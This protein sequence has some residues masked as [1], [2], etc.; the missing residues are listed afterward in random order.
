[1]KKDHISKVKQV[2][3]SNNKIT[4]PVNSELFLDI[5]DQ[6]ASLFSIGPYYYYIFNF[7]NY[8][9]DFVHEGIENV[10]GIKPDDFTIDMLFDIMHPENLETLHLKELHV[11]DF[12]LNQIPKEDLMKYKAMYLMRL[13]NS[14]GRY[15]TILHQV[16]T[17]TMSEEGKMQQIIGVH[18]DVTYLNVPFD[19]RISFIG[20]E[21]PSFYSITPHH[22]YKMI[23]PTLGNLF[24]DREK[25][26]LKKVSE[27]NNF[28][29]IADQLNLSPHTINTHKKNILKKTECTNMAQLLAKCL[30]EGI[31]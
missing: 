13:K 22:E 26:I 12:L 25:Q 20:H 8:K 15:R 11:T 17:L 2:W 16:K 3:E 30:R 18:T 29:E 4:N 23:A 24:S 28:I 9:M 6:V 10:L 5:I 14:K 7:E 21:R 31:I 1:M 19:D 27:G